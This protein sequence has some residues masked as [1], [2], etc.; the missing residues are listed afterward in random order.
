MRPVKEREPEEEGEVEVG[1]GTEGERLTL[2]A[3]R[4]GHHQS[5][6][7]TNSVLKPREMFVSH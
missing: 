2:L 4:P 7:T 3:L 1:V 6:M 5:L